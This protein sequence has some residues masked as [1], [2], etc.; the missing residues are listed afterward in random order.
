MKQDKEERILSVL[1]SC[2][3]STLA[4]MII[5]TSMIVGGNTLEKNR[6]KKEYL[7]DLSNHNTYQSLG[8]DSHVLLLEEE[9]SNYY[10]LKEM[11]IEDFYLLSAVYENKE[12]NSYERETIYKI[13]E[14][15]REDPYLNKEE[16]Y[17]KLK[18]VTISRK[19]KN[20]EKEKGII[21]K[22]SVQILANYNANLNAICFYDYENLTPDTIM[23]EVIHLVYPCTNLS[24]TFAEGLA[25]TM[26]EEYFGYEVTTAY[27]QEIAY[28]KLLCEFLGNDQV[29][30]IASLNDKELLKKSLYTVFL[31]D[32]VVKAW[33]HPEKMQK[34]DVLDYYGKVEEMMDRKNYDEAKKERVSDLFLQF[35]YSIKAD[36]K[37]TY[38][39]ENN[40]KEKV[41]ALR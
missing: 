23:H 16:I 20:K 32:E 3:S 25:E 31:D 10:D 30:K 15:I 22:R 18:T 34:Q 21:E 2:L 41:K 8:E 4:A 14:I 38:F 36:T 40:Q 33:I 6:S 11:S 39:K 37:Q 24:A 29:L 12:L 9:L 1:L 5:A 27:N 28:V 26:N 13:Y 17:S 7:N 19:N 35:A